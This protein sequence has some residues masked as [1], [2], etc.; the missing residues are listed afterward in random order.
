VSSVRTFRARVLAVAGEAGRVLN[1]SLI[2]RESSKHDVTL[3]Y[4]RCA[5]LLPIQELFL[6][7]ALERNPINQIMTVVERLELL[8]RIGM[9]EFA[10]QLHDQYKPLVVYLMLTCFDRLG[11][12]ADWMSFANWLDQ[13]EAREVDMSLS[14]TTGVQQSKRLYSTCRRP[15]G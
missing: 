9:P 4:S 2:A 14:S 1:Y 5:E 7:S 6:T 12:P 13:P 3:A 11:Q 8:E 10:K 15:M